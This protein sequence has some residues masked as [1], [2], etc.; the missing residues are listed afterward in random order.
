[1]SKGNAKVLEGIV[2]S[3]KMAKTIVVKVSRSFRHPFYKKVVR[4]G[5]KYKAHDEEGRAKV[6]DAVRIIETRPLS[7][8]KHF[9]LLEVLGK[10]KAAGRKE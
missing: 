10:E 3:D 7:S 8:D 2:T 9:A 1:M 5:K 6:G 4:R